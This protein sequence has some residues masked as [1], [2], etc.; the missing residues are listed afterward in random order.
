M[1]FTAVDSS[2]NS[3]CVPVLFLQQ[4]TG[5]AWK[6][7]PS[8]LRQNAYDAVSLFSDPGSLIHDGLLEELAEDL[9]K[10][11]DLIRRWKKECLTP[12]ERKYIIP[13]DVQ[14][15]CGQLWSQVAKPKVRAHYTG[16]S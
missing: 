3:H 8:C 7:L 1:F 13:Q 5:A 16:F 11:L 14:A 9:Q 2:V 6:Y 10:E 4:P 15:H 12:S